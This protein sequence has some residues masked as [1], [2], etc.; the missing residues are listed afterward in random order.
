MSS[1]PRSVRHRARCMCVRLRCSTTWMDLTRCFSV[2]PREADGLDPLHRLLLEVSWEVLERAG[3]AQKSLVDSQTGVFVGIG[4][5]EYGS[6]SGVQSLSDLDSHVATSS[7]HSAAAG[8]LAYTLGLQGPTMAVDTACSSS[9]VAVHLAC[10][11]L[12]TG[13]CDMALAG[14]VN[15]MLSPAGSI[16]LS[17]NHALGRRTLQDL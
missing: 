10:Q 15:L 2:S 8:R 11:S 13:E 3:L 14:G 7:G 12:R 17:P 1:M 9:L 4:E 6:V 5:S 16:A